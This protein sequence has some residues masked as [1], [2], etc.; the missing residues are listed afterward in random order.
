[1]VPLLF[2][3]LLAAC[4]SC[5]GLTNVAFTSPD[6]PPGL[7]SRLYAASAE[8]TRQAVL[9]TIAGFERWKIVSQ[10]ACCRYAGEGAARRAQWKAWPEGPLPGEVG[11]LHVEI[12]TQFLRFVD[13]MTIFL[14]PEGRK[15]TRLDVHSASRVGKGDFGVNERNILRLLGALDARLPASPAEQPGSA[16]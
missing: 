6:G 8:E 14:A 5:S 12:T 3:L 7:R 9:E 16:P 4:S 13:D 2:P 10:D 1:M 15:T 11:A